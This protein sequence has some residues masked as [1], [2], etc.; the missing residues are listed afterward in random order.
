MGDAYST[1]DGQDDRA[2]LQEPCERY[3]SRRGAARLRDAV[4]KTTGSGQLAGLEWKPRNEA[5]VV[6]VAIRQHRFTAAVREVVAVLHRRHRKYPPS[7]FDVG[8]RDFAQ[9]RMANDAVVKESAHSAEL[10]VA[11][12]SR[13][14]SMELPEIDLLDA[15][16]PEAAFG[17]CNQIR[18]T[19]IGNPLVGT[20]TRQTRLGSDKQPF[21]GVKGLADQFLRNIGINRLTRFNRLGISCGR[22]LRCRILMTALSPFLLDF[23][24]QRCGADAQLLRRFGPIAPGRAQRRGNV[25]AF[26][27]GERANLTGGLNR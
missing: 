21:I 1:G 17:L 18:G 6:G 5:D 27:L 16:S 3:L 14:D 13:I 25:V 24:I 4:D 2:S 20:R 15:E 19:S 10:F 23:S 26:Q 11:R 22:P 12:D 7:G 8:H 9:P